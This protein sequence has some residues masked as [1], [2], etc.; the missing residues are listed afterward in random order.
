ATKLEVMW[1][2]V[3]EAIQKNKGAAK[4]VAK[5]YDKFVSTAQGCPTYAVPPVPG[6]IPPC[7]CG[8]AAFLTLMG[9]TVQSCLCASMSPPSGCPAP[10]ATVYCC[11]TAGDPNDCTNTVA[12]PNVAACAPTPPPASNLILAD[13]GSFNAGGT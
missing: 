10:P 2:Q 9:Y 6:T 5:V 3:E 4:V 11:P 12:T 8:E 13:N 7:A 1:A